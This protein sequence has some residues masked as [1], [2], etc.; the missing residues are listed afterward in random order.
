MEPVNNKQRLKL[1]GKKEKVETTPVPPK[2]DTKEVLLTDL[3]TIL[4]DIESH[5]KTLATIKAIEY[6]EAHPQPEPPAQENYQDAIE[7]AVAKILKEQNKK[8][9]K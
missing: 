5:L 8:G 9:K 1:F 2:P 7:Q 4:S 6:D 3:V